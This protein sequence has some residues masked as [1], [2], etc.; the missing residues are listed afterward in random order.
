VPP[1]WLTYWT[2]NDVDKSYEK[3]R[4]LGATGAMAPMDIP[5]TGRVATVVDPTG[6]AFALFKPAPMPG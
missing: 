3:A 1:S 4:S 6:A 2:V 5:N